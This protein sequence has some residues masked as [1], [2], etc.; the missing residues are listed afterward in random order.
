MACS[1]LRIP[2]SS[3]LFSHSV[4]L[5]PRRAAVTAAS[6]PP[7]PPPATSTL[8][9]FRTGTISIPSSSCP[10]MG[11][12]AQRRV[13]VFTRS[14]IQVKHRKH[15]TMSSGWFAITLDGKYG[16]ASNSLPISIISALPEAMISSIMAGSFMAPKVATGTCTCFLTSAARW[17]LQPCS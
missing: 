7:T 1:L 5:W 14:D 2:P 3:P 10:I 8:L 12:T 9:G 16:S 4:T 15:F 17:T 13:D 11:L 6:M